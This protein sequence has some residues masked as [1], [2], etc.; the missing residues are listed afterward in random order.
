MRGFERNP[1]NLLRFVTSSARD[2]G[3]WLVL[4]GYAV[5]FALHAVAIVQLPLYLAQSLVAVALPV[6]ALAAGLVEGRLSRG[7]WGSVAALTLGLA[8]VAAGAGSAG[9]TVT[10]ATFGWSVLAAVV[11]LAAATWWGRRRSGALLGSLA[12]LGYAGTAVTVRGVETPVTPVVLLCA[13]AVPV[14][15]TLAFWA[16][17]LGMRR[18]LIAATTGPMTVLQTLIPAALG[19]AFLDDTVRT[20]WWPVVL[21]GLLVATVAAVVLSR[22]SELSAEVA[23]LG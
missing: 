4:V 7:R 5:G 16:Y 11:A 13:V 17:S 15:G 10:T 18:A 12:G 23:P 3:S 9:R 20:G 14:L 2:A 1:D 8:L 22:D 21:V 6:T 19:V